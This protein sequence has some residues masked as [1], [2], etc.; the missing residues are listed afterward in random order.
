MT[1][2]L[3]LQEGGQSDQQVA[4]PY[5]NEPRRHKALIV[6]SDKPF[7]AESPP[8]VLLAPKTPQQ[9]FYVRNHLPVPHVDASTWTVRGLVHTPAC[10]SRQDCLPCTSAVPDPA[11]QAAA[12]RR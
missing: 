3:L 1:A 7:N 8:E 5:A 2:G 9:L 4:D 12:A 10:S 11:P 6:R